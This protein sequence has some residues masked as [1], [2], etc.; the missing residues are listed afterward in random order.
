MAQL[1]D[2]YIRLQTT[3]HHDKLQISNIQLS[4]QSLISATK[5]FK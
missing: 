4:K 3:N 1:N 2:A 5:K